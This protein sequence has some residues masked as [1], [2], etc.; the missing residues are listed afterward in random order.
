MRHYQSLM[1]LA[2]DAQKPMFHLRPADGAIGSHMAAVLR[3]REEFE[4]LARTLL[5]RAGLSA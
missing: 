1:P 5:D 3:C 2:Q 4:T